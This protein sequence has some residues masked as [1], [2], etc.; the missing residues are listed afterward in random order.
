MEVK[1][2]C[3]RPSHFLTIRYRSSLALAG[4]PLKLHLNHH[5]YRHI[6][7]AQAKDRI[8]DLPGLFVLQGLSDKGAEF[9]PGGDR[10]EA[11]HGKAPS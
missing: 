1:R 8:D 10:G 5:L 2:Y 7:E 9:C 4:S 6:A 11:Y 3:L